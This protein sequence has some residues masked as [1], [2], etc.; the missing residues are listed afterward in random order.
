MEERSLSL[1]SMGEK[2]HCASRLSSRGP[3]A[4]EDPAQ[5]LWLNLENWWT[6]S[7]LSNFKPSHHPPSYSTLFISYFPLITLQFIDCF[8]ITFHIPLITFAF[9][10]HGVYCVFGDTATIDVRVCCNLPPPRRRWPWHRLYSQRARRDS[11]ATRYAG[12]L[13]YHVEAPSCA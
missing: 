7:V 9:D 5:L 10:F 3:S 4:C 8:N 13:D 2:R 6:F 12:L 11:T 1:V